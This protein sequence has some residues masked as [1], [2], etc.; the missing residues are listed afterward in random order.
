MVLYNYQPQDTDYESFSTC[1]YVIPYYRYCV[2]KITAIKAKR[3]VKTWRFQMMPESGTLHHVEEVVV[4][5]GHRQLVNEEF[6]C[7]D[8][9]HRM[10]DFTQDPHFLQF[11]LSREQLFFT[12][13]GTVVVD[14]RKTRFSA[15]LRE[16]CSSMLP[17]PLNSS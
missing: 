4:S 11:F 9:T 12:G 17:V 15:I 2:V 8:L 6:H 3:H 5:L 1:W 16:R 14:S 13:T 10:D 7:I